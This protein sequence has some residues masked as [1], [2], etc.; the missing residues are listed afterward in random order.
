MTYIEINNERYEVV[1]FNE[2]SEDYEWSRRKTCYVT[3]DMTYDEVKNLFQDDME[4]F[5][6]TS[7]SYETTIENEEGFFEIKENITENIRDLSEYNMVG[8]II[9]H[10]DGLLTVVMGQPTAE[11]L[12]AIL[13]GE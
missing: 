7:E 5:F 2:V 13:L 10:R 3:L 1:K 6:V 8:N 11:E 9:I 4:W 12:L